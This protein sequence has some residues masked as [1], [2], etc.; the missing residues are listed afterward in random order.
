MILYIQLGFHVN[1]QKQ[2]V[3]IKYISQN[4]ASLFSH[5]IS[6]PLKV[7]L[8]NEEQWYVFSSCVCTFSCSFKS[9]FKMNKTLFT[10][11]KEV[12]LANFM[13]HLMHFQVP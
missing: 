6:G 4:T 8:G 13:C 12:R 10:L 7:Y 5:V 1:N 11:G 3:L 9:F 2:K